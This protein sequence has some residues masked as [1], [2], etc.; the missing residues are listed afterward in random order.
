MVKQTYPRQMSCPEVTG[1][2]VWV[3]MALQSLSFLEVGL[4]LK[5]SSFPWG[6]IFEVQS[7]RVLS[8]HIHVYAMHLH[9]S[10]SAAEAFLGG[11]VC[12]KVNCRTDPEGKKICFTDE[13][14]VQ[15][16][17]NSLNLTA[18]ALVLSA[19][20]RKALW[21]R[22]WIAVFHKHPHYFRVRN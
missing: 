16:W 21:F 8:Q 15:L 2:P 7:S 13:V 12:G 4:E 6:N 17:G 14:C 10:C 9:S 20:S 19:P 18:D 5:I 1:Y 11:K 3:L 22:L